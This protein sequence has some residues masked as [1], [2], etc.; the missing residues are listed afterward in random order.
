MS[1]WNGL[2]YVRATVESIRAQTF[3]DFEFVIVDN[4]STDGTREFLRELA[5]AE[6]RVRLILNEENLGHSGGLNRGLAECRGEWVARIDADDIAL[7]ERLTRQMAFLRENPDVRLASSLAFYIDSEGRRVGKTFHPLST[8][9]VFRQYM[10]Q[11]EMIGILHPG[12]IMDRALVQRLGGYR[13]AFGAANDI[14]LWCR[15]AEAGSV[16]LVQQ[17]R[18]MEYRVHPGAIS[19]SFDAARIKYEWARACAIARRSAL[20]EPTWESF[21]AE[22]DAKPLLHR[23]NRARKTRAKAAYRQAGLDYICGHRLR[24]AWR[25]GIAALLQPAYA[26]RRITG[27][28]LEPAQP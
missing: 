13:E 5:T 12:A 11:N 20:P 24:A 1:V 17:E 16:I 21:I 10:A 15:I 6:P 25:F 2:P 18:L 9:E 22:R 3:T 4:V 8:R 7:P 26:L 27:Q 14:D 28:R 23:I 19:N